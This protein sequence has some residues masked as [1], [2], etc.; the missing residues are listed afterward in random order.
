MGKIVAVWS[1]SGGVGKTEIAKN[2][3]LTA[4]QTY[5]VILLDANLCNPDI[6]EHLGLYYE[7]GKTLSAAL[8]LWNEKRLTPGA[9]RKILQPYQKISVL[10]GSEDTIEQT[11]YSPVFFRDLLRTLSQLADFV[12]ADMD[13]DITSPAGISILLASHHVI[14]PFSTVPSTLGHGKVYMD[15]LKE[16]Y[17]MNPHKFDPVLNRAGEGGSVSETDIE[18]CM[19]RPVIATIPYRKEYLQSACKGSPLVLEKRLLSKKLSRTLQNVVRKYAQKD[20]SLG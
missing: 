3:A 12:I 7:Q 20:V 6:A 1:P 15:L 16:S 18:I 10:V 2:L 8:Q 11:D 4:G 14:T 13:S 17:Q 19:K 9:L 5:R